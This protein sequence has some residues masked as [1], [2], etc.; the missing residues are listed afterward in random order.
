M[1]DR[2]IV[3]SPTK[4]LAC[5]VI[6]QAALDLAGRAVTHRANAARFFADLGPRS[7]LRFWANIAGVDARWISEQARRAGK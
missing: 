1:D 3:K 4:T 2:I 5:A 6:E 7:A